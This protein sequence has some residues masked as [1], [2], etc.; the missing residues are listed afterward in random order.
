MDR[1]AMQF[2]RGNIDYVSSNVYCA[3][4]SL[5]R[6]MIDT[7]HCVK[8]GALWRGHAGRVKA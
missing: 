1:L 5:G 8:P 7:M 6:A 4:L 3:T 2:N